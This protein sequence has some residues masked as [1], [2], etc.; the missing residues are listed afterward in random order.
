MSKGSGGSRPDLPLRRRPEPPRQETAGHKALPQDE[1]KLRAIIDKLTSHGTALLVV[2]QPATIGA[3]PV[4]VAEAVGFVVGY[5]PGLAMTR[6][7]DLHPSESKTDSR[8]DYIT[9]NV[10][11]PK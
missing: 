7:D 10:R 1:A 8:D 9:P 11:H 5:L 2:D 4:V 6:I 3:P